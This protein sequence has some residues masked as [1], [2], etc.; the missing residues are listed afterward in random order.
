MA[1]G[2][3]TESGTY[4]GQAPGIAVE[5]AKLPPLSLLCDPELWVPI[6]EPPFPRLHLW[7]YGN[8]RRS[9]ME[10]AVQ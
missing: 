3:L 9:S 2:I 5:Q 6:S 1:I 10:V 7:D 8:E 4:E